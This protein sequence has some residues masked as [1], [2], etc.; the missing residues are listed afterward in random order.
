MVKRIGTFRS[1]SRYKLK[2]HVRRRGKLSLTK[3]FQKFNIGD[4]VVLKAEPAYQKAMYFP[5][6]HGK[7]GI[8]QS[9][10]GNCYNVLIKDHDKEK[11]MIVHPVHLIKV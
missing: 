8:I 9:K 3:Y 2:K 5:R 11:T 4:R 6:F 1:G 10:K 7:T